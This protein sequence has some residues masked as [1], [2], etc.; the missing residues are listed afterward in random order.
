MHTHH[1]HKFLLLLWVS[2]L[3]SSFVVSEYVLPYASPIVATWLRFFI[4]SL[5]LLPIVGIRSGFKIGRMQLLQYGTISLFLVLFFVGLFESLKTTTA[6]RTAVIYTVLPLLCVL[7]SYLLLKVVPKAMQL[8]GFLL[9]VCGAIWTLLAANNKMV[10]LTE[11]FEGDTLF[12]LSC[13]SLAVHVV[14]TKKWA[15]DQP[16]LLS[17]FFILSLGCVLLLPFLFLSNSPQDI[18]KGSELFWFSIMYLTLFTTLG[19]F[20]LQQ[21]LL[22]SLSPNAF[23]AATY[24]VPVLVIL[25]EGD[26]KA[27][28]FM[29]CTPAF[30]LT[31]LA[32]YLIARDA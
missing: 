8:L 21:Y 16:A 13:F 2:L 5:C 17:S 15:S 30:L 18:T 10:N 14:L 27:S 12:L 32:L 24:L 29:A 6:Q 3:A 1:L 22:K 31:G 4:T 25:F 9:G 23:I 11:W 26:S 20:F 7:L 28:V 19:T